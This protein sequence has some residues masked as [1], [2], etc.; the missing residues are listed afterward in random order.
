MSGGHFDYHQTRIGEIAQ[1]I[2][3]DIALALKPKPAKIHEDYWT[4]AEK[5]YPTSWHSFSGFTTFNSYYEAEAFL[6]THRKVRLADPQ[7]VSG[8]FFGENDVIFQSETECMEGTKDGETIPVLYAIHHAEYDRYPYDEEVLELSEETIETMK[9]AYR[10]MR[11]AEIYADRVDWLMSGDD[12]EETLKERLQS[13]LD[14]FEKEFQNKD[15]TK[16]YD[17]EDEE[18]DE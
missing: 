4:I 6:L 12:G 18:D 9:E 8:R 5:D 11:I 16:C 10:Q 17:E 1:K 3:E 2:E 15:W 13:E 14:E 7:Y